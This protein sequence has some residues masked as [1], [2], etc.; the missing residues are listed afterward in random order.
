M[1]L[2]VATDRNWPGP[3]FPGG[4]GKLTLAGSAIASKVRFLAQPRTHTG[5]QKPP[6]ANDRSV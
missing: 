5:G 4:R 3:G 6:A 2:P 1:K